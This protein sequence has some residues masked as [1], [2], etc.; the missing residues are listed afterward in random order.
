MINKELI[1]LDSDLSNK[2]DIIGY[3]AVKAKRLG[4]LTNLDAYIQAVE[5]REKEFSTAIGYEVSI[6][7]GK[8]EAV[9]DA[10]IAF[11]RTKE[12]V[13]WDHDTNQQVRLVFLLGVPESKK[14]NLHLKIL[15]QI[16]RRLLDEKFRECLLAVD[17]ENAFEQLMEIEKNIIAM[18]EK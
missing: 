9:N 13:I 18:E 7:H 17:Q 11:M 5:N 1:I 3:L 10:F 6:P 12:P 15:A 2:E 16:S 4:Y 14:E 8:S